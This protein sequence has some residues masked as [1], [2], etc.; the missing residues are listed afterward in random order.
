M[1][2]TNFKVLMHC[3]VYVDSNMLVKGIYECTKPFI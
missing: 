2:E 3:G 1:K